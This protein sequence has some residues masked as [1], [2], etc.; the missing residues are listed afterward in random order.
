MSNHITIQMC[1]NNPPTSLVSEIGDY[2]VWCLQLWDHYRASVAIAEGCFDG[3]WDKAEPA[4]ERAYNRIVDGEMKSHE[5]LTLSEGRDYNLDIFILRAPT[6]ELKAFAQH[7]A[8]TAI[9]YLPNVGGDD[10]HYD[11]YPDFIS[12][13][14]QLCSQLNYPEPYNHFHDALWATGSP[15]LD[16]PEAPDMFSAKLT[17]G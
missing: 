7:W 14:H 2:T 17:V 3:D 10:T 6:T 16:D 1:H 9:E 5:P 8:N 12:G 13:L 15:Y 4:V 11:Y